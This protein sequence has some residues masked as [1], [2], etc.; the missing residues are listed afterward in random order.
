M[1]F[2]PFIPIIAKQHQACKPVILTFTPPTPD[3]QHTPSFVEHEYIDEEM[4]S[5]YWESQASQ[6]E[7]DSEW[8]E[9]SSGSTSEGSVDSS[10]SDMDDGDELP[11]ILE[12]D[13]YY[14]KMSASERMQMKTESL[15]GRL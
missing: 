4:L 6:S 3:P 1:Q 10:W 11:D 9:Q 12:D 5:P 15:Y 13:F 14:P 2:P 8:D 7:E